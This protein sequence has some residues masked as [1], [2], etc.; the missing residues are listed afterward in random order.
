[1]KSAHA[2]F[3]T[4]GRRFAVRR[5]VQEF[6]YVRVGGRR[7][8][9]TG[10]GSVDVRTPAGGAV[11]VDLGPSHRVQQTRFGAGATRGWPAVSVAVA[12]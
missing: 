8:T 1:M 12:G 6:L 4:S 11:V 9:L 2:A 7:L 10:S 5:R 3:T